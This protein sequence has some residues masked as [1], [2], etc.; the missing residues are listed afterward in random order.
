MARHWHNTLVAC[1][2]CVEK[3]E[4]PRPGNQIAQV[5]KSSRRVSVTKR[6]NL[7]IVNA[8]EPVGL[9]HAVPDAPEKRSE[10]FLSGRTRKSYADAD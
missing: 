8:A 2:S 1:Q 9:H 4:A 6:A 5:A 7:G 10:Q 3:I